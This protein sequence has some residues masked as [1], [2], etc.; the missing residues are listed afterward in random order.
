MHPDC[1]RVVE[2]PHA[3]EWLHHQW[4][5][6]RRLL[7]G[8]RC[9]WGSAGKTQPPASN[10]FPWVQT[11]RLWVLPQP[12]SEYTQNGQNLRWSTIYESLKHLFCFH[13]VFFFC[14]FQVLTIFSASNYYEV[15]SNRGAYIRMGPDLVPHFVQYQASRT[16]RELT[17]RQRY[18]V[19][20]ILY[21][22]I[23][24][25][26]LYYMHKLL[27]LGFKA[28]AVSTSMCFPSVLAGQ[29][30]QLCELWVNNCMYISQ[31]SSVPSRSLIPT[32]QVLCKEMYYFKL[33]P[34][35]FTT[36]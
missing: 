22:K 16:C 19:L 13:W 11:G 2:W 10:P 6:R 8:T 31:I 14:C 24:V 3:P 36:L 33:S 12:Q 35:F 30:D 20:Y 4:G 27:D 1:G 15:G 25:W 29:R 9:H 18:L 7:L 23:A 32:T 5:E 26:L 28:F 21:P 17:L 34:F